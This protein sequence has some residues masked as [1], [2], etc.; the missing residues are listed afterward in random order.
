[1]TKVLS[2]ESKSNCWSTV[3]LNIHR[4]LH[5]LMIFF[6]FALYIRIILQMNQFILI[7]WVSETYQFNF[8]EI[9]RI[10]SFIIAFLA[11]VTWVAIIFITI[12]LTLSKEAYEFSESPVHVCTSPLPPGGLGGGTDVN[13]LQK[14]RGRFAHLFDGVSLNKKSRLF[15][16]LLQ[17]R[18]AV[19]I[20]LLITVGPKSSIIVISILVGLQLVYLGLLVAIRPYKEISC[21]IIDI[22]NEVYFLVILASLLKYNTAADWEGTPTTA[23]ISSIKILSFLAIKYK[24]K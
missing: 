19:F 11:L 2:K 7:S 3:L 21:N 16:W 8:Y 23:Y 22:T 6:T 4:I 13:N 10:I 17:I 15:V 18:R 12:L 1:M 14:K 5:K 9:K 24:I 20:I